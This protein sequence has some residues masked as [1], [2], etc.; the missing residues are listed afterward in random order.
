MTSRLHDSGWRSKES[1]W[2]HSKAF[3]WQGKTLMGT[4]FREEGFRRM[5]G[6]RV[7]R[8]FR[9]QATTPRRNGTHHADAGEEW[10]ESWD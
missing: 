4:E 9:S 3:E 5:H 6:Q 10:K 1:G 2:L 7:Q 8:G